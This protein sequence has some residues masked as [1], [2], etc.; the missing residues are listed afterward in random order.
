M[1]WNDDHRI[2]AVAGL[3]VQYRELPHDIFQHGRVPNVPGLGCRKV[4]L[5]TRL[6]P[7]PSLNKVSGNKALQ[8]ATVPQQPAKYSI[9][10]ESLLWWY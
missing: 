7:S 4:L 6:I 8:P 3:R 5:R 9:L 10:V 1:A 2:V